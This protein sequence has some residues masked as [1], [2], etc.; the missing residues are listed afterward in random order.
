MSSLLSLFAC[1]YCGN[2]SDQAAPLNAVLMALLALPFVM[3]ALG[4]WVIAWQLRRAA[5]KGAG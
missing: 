2:Q 3:L 5:R 1:P 4:G